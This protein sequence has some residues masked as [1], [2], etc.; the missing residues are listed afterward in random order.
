M[1][2]FIEILKHPFDSGLLT[3]FGGALA[4]LG[5]YHLILFFQQRL[6]TYLYYSLYVFLLFLAIFRFTDDFP[7]FFQGFKYIITE[8]TFVVYFLFVFSFLDMKEKAPKWNNIILK[9]NYLFL[10]LVIFI[11]V[12]FLFNGS[13]HLVSLGYSFFLAYMPVLAVI[14][15]VPIFRSPNPLKFYVIIGS[16]VLFLTWMGPVMIYQLNLGIENFKIA[17]SI[18][19]MGVIFENFLFSLGL[20]RKQRMMIGENRAAHDKIIQQYREN[21]KLRETVQEK[22]EENLRLLNIKAEQHELEK[23]KTRYEKELAELKI[24]ALRSQMNP[25]FIFNSLNSIKLYIINNEKEN[26]VYYLNKFS[27]LIRKILDATRQNSISLSEEM[28]TMQLY[29]SIE[30]IRFNG[31]LIFELEK[32][33][34]LFLEDIKLPSLILQPFLENAIWHGLPLASEKKLN[35]RWKSI[36]ITAWRS[37]LKIAELAENIP[38]K[39]ILKNSINANL[40]ELK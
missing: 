20:G 14:A 36:S 40:S 39:S 35:Y 4:A 5:L 31:E 34:E 19:M 21:E 22:L 26:A 9:A 3:F 13:L 1:D 27:K 18:F 17:A 32:D 30:N 23:I 10:S 12:L 29:V 15:Y 33:P 16:A 8:V 25:H 11:Q 7:V 38:K 6:M 24:L 28:E 2:G 37:I